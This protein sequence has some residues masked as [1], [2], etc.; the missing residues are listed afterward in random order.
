MENKTHK[1][2]YLNLDVACDKIRNSNVFLH[3]S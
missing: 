2:K 3:F 1:E